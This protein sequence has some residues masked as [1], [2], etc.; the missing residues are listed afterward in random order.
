MQCKDLRDVDMLLFILSTSSL[1][2]MWVN[3]WDYEGLLKYSEIPPKVFNA[4]LR[5]LIERGLLSGCACGCRGDF[6]VTPEGKQWL[7]NQ[8]LTWIKGE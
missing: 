1:K 3:T 4:K 7:E 8:F 2:Q 6:E 5:R